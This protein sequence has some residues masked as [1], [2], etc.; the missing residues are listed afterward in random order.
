M[1]VDSRPARRRRTGRLAALGIVAALA[2]VAAHGG[3]AVASVP[4]A[5][6]ADAPLRAQLLGA[7][8]A[9]VRS[10]RIVAGHQ[11]LSPAALA[12]RHEIA[13][14]ESAARVALVQHA[15]GAAASAGWCSTHGASVGGWTGTLPNLPICGPGPA[16]GGTAAYVDLPGP[17]GSL[18]G[19]YNAT[20][21][22][23]CVELAERY[24]ALVDG[25]A[26]VEANGDQVAANYHAAYPRSLLVVNGSP[27]AVG[28][29]P[30]RGD[31]ISFSLS[32]SFNDPTDG[33]VAV[34]VASA[35]N[36]AGDGTVEVAQEN[37]S[38]ADYRMTLELTRWRLSDPS[39]PAMAA[40]QYPDAEWFQPLAPPAVGR[41]ATAL[42]GPPPS[43]LAARSAAAV[44]ADLLRRAG[45]PLTAA[46]GEARALV[47]ALSARP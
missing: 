43:A 26:P 36:G 24:L 31:V 29:A 28:H 7:P 5:H 41:L 44:A 23:Q 4:H 27:A 34:V 10:P 42:A 38:S 30:V 37:V 2:G 32:P 8:R 21:G 33:H 40:L 18:A 47:E 13:R 12:L 22:F 20:P 19:Y 11:V 16:Y 3:S 14:A 39:D 35:V 6:R 1:P 17:G 45:A 25:L 9:L 15:A 46:R